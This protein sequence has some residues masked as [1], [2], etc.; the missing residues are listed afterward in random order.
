MS[1]REKL[2]A[3]GLLTH[4]GRT[5]LLFG[6]A[7]MLPTS[8]TSI[9]RQGVRAPE[10]GPDCA[11]LRSFDKWGRVIIENDES[12]DSYIP[13]DPPGN[14]PLTCPLA[15]LSSPFP[16][17]PPP[18]AVQ[19]AESFTISVAGGVPVPY[20]QRE[21]TPASRATRAQILL[22]DGLD[23]V[24]A[25]TVLIRIA[26]NLPRS[27]ELPPLEI[28]ASEYPDLVEVTNLAAYWRGQQRQFV[29]LDQARITDF[30]SCKRVDAVPYPSCRHRFEYGNLDVNVSFDLSHLPR[31][32]H[33]KA[34]STRF[35][36]C[37]TRIDA[38]GSTL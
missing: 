37:I 11:Y 10:L 25:A 16:I 24:K 30:V 35:I 9:A 15:A 38:G 28:R 36:G 1:S 8:T 32:R 23:I 29:V 33:L 27:F 5:A 13:D 20:A 21:N 26:M 7:I 18:N 14:V 19:S 6:A 34:L 2:F 22:T 4:R 17:G 12:I 3:V 31:W